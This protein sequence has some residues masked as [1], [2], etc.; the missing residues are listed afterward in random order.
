MI[1]SEDI[2]LVRQMPLFESLSDDQL[3]C[4]S[5]GEIVE[6]APGEV[7]ATYGEAATFF[8]VLLVGENRLWRSYDRQDVLMA[9]ANPGSFFGEIPI[10]V[11]G[12]WLATVRVS[13]PSRLLRLD[14]A[15]FWK[16]MGGCPTVA[17]QILR[18]VAERF[19]NL[20][21]YAHQ[22]EKLAS[23]GTMAAGLAHEL[24]NP[25]SAALR[26]ASDSQR[27]SESVQ[28]HLCELIERL[29]EA[30]WHH[31]GE[32][33]EQSMER[34]RAAPS[35]DA[36]ARSDREEEVGTWL[37]S[38]GI[39]EGWKMSGTFV[40][41]GLDV[42]W[43]QE[44]LAGLPAESRAPAVQWIEA[45]LSVKQ[46]LKQVENSTGRI[47]E[48][49]KAV[50]SYTH[51][52][53]SAREDLDIHEGIEST[54][55]MLG[56][57]LKS[58]TVRRAF[59]RTLP[60][61]WAYGGELNQVWTNLID[62]AIDAVGGTGKICVGTFRESD[63]IRVEIIDN[64]PGIPPDV[65]AHI[66]EPFFTTKGVGSGTGLGLVICHRIIADRHGGEIEFD[67]KPGETRFS[68][69]L[70]VGNGAEAAKTAAA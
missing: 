30:A 45:R 51:M 15:G 49:V 70:P 20:E 61:V 1:T 13:Q 64:G 57:K 26:A 43:L 9:T 32:Y 37:E 53:N 56:H 63:H 27:V 22:R 3:G 39:P 41:A 34:Q 21:G 23:L 69:R 66:F 12:P 47:V 14:P 44:F 38:Q 8:Y 52:D 33:S 10:L 60:R 7:L 40:A 6:S 17:R 35:L 55:T 4:I 19:R 65:Q 5:G 46:L 67:S 42:K 36:L 68:V 54:L 28:S 11:D 48:L 62:N 2:K 18:T 59:D 58:V 29:D 50:K 24:N 31:L 16:M 25:A